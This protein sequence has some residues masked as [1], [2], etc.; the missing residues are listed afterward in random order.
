[1]P[2][3]CHTMAVGHKRKEEFKIWQ[4]KQDQNVDYVEE[5]A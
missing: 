3:H 5:K 1:M 2:H 4:E